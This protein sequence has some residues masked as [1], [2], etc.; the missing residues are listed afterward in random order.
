MKSYYLDKAEQNKPQIFQKVVDT[1]QYG[2]PVQ[3]TSLWLQYRFD[4]REEPESVKKGDSFCIDFGSHYT[5]YLSFRM[6]MVQRYPDAPV[7]VRIKVAESLYELGRDFETYQGALAGSWL[8]EDVI[9]IDEPSVVELPR[10]YAF[11][12][13]KVTVESMG[14]GYPVRL[15]DFKVTAVTS[16]DTTK[17]K[18]VALDHELKIMDKIGCRTLENCM[19]DVFE[20]GPKRDRRLWLGDLRLQALTGYYTLQS[21]NVAKRC[22][23]LFA[24]HTE[25]GNRVPRDIFQNSTGTFCEGGWLADYALMF[26]VCLCDYYEYTNDLEVV[27]DLFALEDEQVQIAWRDTE[28]GVVKE[29]DGWWAFIDW[30]DEL[31]KVTSVQGIFLYALDKMIQLCE[32]SGRTQK[33]KEYTEYAEVLRRGAMEQLYDQASGVFA[34]K[35]DRFQLSVHSQ[36][37]MVLGGVVEGKNAQD[38]MIKILQDKEAKQAVT[39]YMHHYVVEAL[40]KSGLDDMAL[41]YVK[42]Y[43]GEMVKCGADTYW[44]VF[45][46]GDLTVSPYGDPIINSCC[47]AWSCSVSYFIRKYWS[48]N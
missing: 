5:G 36:V 13:I 21:V 27:D 38:L 43:W 18:E 17:F 45:V 30:C 4:E 40:L 29:L 34:N 48:R 28:N 33:A 31:Q 20:D 8:Q 1:V 23:Y 3:D 22:M 14:N 2:W 42:E 10:R 6:S 25:P 11:R 26:P 32:K 15:S 47:H 44:E 16:A 9:S 24:A 35:Y 46:P 41:T 12:Y 39:P 7:K 37:W 19:Q